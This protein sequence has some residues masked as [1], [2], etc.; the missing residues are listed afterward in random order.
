MLTCTECVHVEVCKLRA[1]FGEYAEQCEYLELR[2]HPQLTESGSR[3][4]FPY[5]MRRH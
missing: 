3:E 5:K 1:E 2:S 4:G